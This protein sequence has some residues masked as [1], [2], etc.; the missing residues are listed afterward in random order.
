MGESLQVLVP[1]LRAPLRGV[2]HAAH[3]CRTAVLLIDNLE[4]RYPAVHK[5]FTE[6][7]LYLESAGITSL[8][9]PGHAEDTTEHMIDLLGGVSFLRS[10]GWERVVVMVA[11]R[12]EIGPWEIVRGETL[13]NLLTTLRAREASLPN[14]ITAL[15]DLVATIRVAT[16]SVVGVAVVLASE[17]PQRAGQARAARRSA[18]RGG[19]SLRMVDVPAPDDEVVPPPDLPGADV[20]VPSGP[21]PMLFVQLPGSADE[22]GQAPASGLRAGVPADLAILSRL[23]LWC[24]AWVTCE[25]QAAEATGQSA[26]GLGPVGAV[27]AA[28]DYTED[29]H[30]SS[31]TDRHPGPL[32]EP[33]W[34]HA[35]LIWLDREWSRLLQGA[36][37]LDLASVP[38]STQAGGGAVCA[39]ATAPGWSLRASREMW[40]LL[41]AETRMA[42]LRVCHEAFLG[43]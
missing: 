11:T 20:V 24:R 41:D 32:R 42:W 22:T 10:L 25:T 6:L 19:S 33:S 18:A 9:F 12:G 34:M 1:T 3:G 40:A 2:L 17:Q 30:A 43:A 26:E 37:L 5:L 27:H 35:R 39:F 4:P 8:Q 36:G 14:F 23:Y 38:A 13:A 29:A 15:Q 16:E 7:V 21:E 31:P 28:A